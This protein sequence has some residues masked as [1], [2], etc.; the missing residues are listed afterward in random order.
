M[1]VMWRSHFFYGHPIF[2]RPIRSFRPVLLGS[3]VRLIAQL[4]NS[5][6]AI[7][8]TLGKITRQFLRDHKFSFKQA[9]CRV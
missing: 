9:A 2:F 1:C 4:S 5:S 6:A 3:I 8:S 7:T